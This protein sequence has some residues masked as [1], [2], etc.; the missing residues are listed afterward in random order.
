MQKSICY[1]KSC[2]FE[3]K[4]KLHLLKSALSSVK[5]RF[6]MHT[7]NVGKACYFPWHDLTRDASFTLKLN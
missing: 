5:A 7:L 6:S 3:D 4:N 1:W 2:D